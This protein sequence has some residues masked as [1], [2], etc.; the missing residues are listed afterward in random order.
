MIDKVVEGAFP[1]TVDG[2][3]LESDAVVIEGSTY[4]PVKAFGE[5]IGY[6][7]GFDSALGVSMTK[8]ADSPHTAPPTAPN[9]QEIA[10]KIEVIDN[11]IK[12]KNESISM[13]Q[14]MLDYNNQ[15]DQNAPHVVKALEDAIL[16]DKAEITELEK[17]KAELSK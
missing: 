12:I 2:K 4:L 13:N 5:A 11:Q 10:K 14:S 8:N 16:R 15:K 9:P 17:Q 3:K 7:V 6:T 1:V